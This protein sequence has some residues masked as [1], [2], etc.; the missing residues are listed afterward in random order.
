MEMRER[1]RAREELAPL[2][3]SPPVHARAHRFRGF[4]SAQLSLVVVAMAASGYYRVE[5]DACFGVDEVV[6]LMIQNSD[7][8]MLNFAPHVPKSTDG[9]VDAPGTHYSPHNWKGRVMPNIG[10][11]LGGDE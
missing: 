7:G 3:A 8:R 4:F 9:K 2:P 6:D 11:S 10:F 1:E 5:L